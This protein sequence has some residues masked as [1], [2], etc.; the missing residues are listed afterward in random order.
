MIAVSIEH[1]MAKRLLVLM[2][3]L[4]LGGAWLVWRR[5]PTV[6]MTS[7]SVEH[8]PKNALQE[9]ATSS[10]AFVVRA[11]DGDTLIVQLD[12]EKQERRVRLLGIN[13]PETVDPR[14]PVECFGKEASKFMHELVDGRRVRL[15]ADTQADE[16]DAYGRLLRSVFLEDGTDINLVMVHDGY[17]YAYLSFPLNPLRKR[18]LK[19]QQEDAKLS[20]RGLWNPATCMG[21]TPQ[22]KNTESVSG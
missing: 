7:V 15:E 11:V 22:T 5:S 20:E 6:T 12:G 2:T 19:K 4:A 1:S 14:K 10:N 3:L 18:A 16:R 17:A 8:R 13:T 21:S 9:Y